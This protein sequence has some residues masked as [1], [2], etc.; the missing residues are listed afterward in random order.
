MRRTARGLLAMMVV[1]VSAAAAL[2]VERFPPPDFTDHQLPQTTTPH[3]RWLGWEYFD[4]AALAAGLVLASYFALGRRS[5]KGLVGLATVAMVWLGF[6]RQGCVCAI[7]AIQNVSL[8]VFDPSYTVPLTVIAFFALPLLVTLFFG[9]TFCAAVC[10]L[11]AVQELTLVR[12]VRVPGWVDQSLGLV[13]FIYLGAAV[14]FAA[15]G[16]GFIICQYDPYVGFFRLSGNAAMITFGICLLVIGLFIGRPY[17]RYLCP[18]GAIFGLFSRV[19][20]RH[21]RIPPD[22]CIQC[23][24]CE[25]ACPYGAIR[26]PTVPQT[27]AE[28]ARGRRRLGWM[29]AL[30]PVLVVVGTGLGYTLAT[31]LSL[32]HREVRLAE[33]MKLEEAGKVEGTIDASDAFRNTGRPARE[34]YTEAIALRERFAFLGGLLGGWVGLVIGMKL[35]HLSIRRKRDEYSPDP[36]WCVSCGRCFEYCPSEQ[37]T[38]IQELPTLE[39]SGV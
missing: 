6:W 17:C 34:L 26:P 18:L 31:P 13:P 33:R 12:P 32:V 19:S 21:V 38:L 10:P 39:K 22:E 7:G 24:L 36:A 28:R 9:R 1:A 23:R 2:A 37:Q 35:V 11:G 29:L 20:G 4:M 5:R 14:L 15:T 27:P 3:G 8:A 16:A 30:A 25:D